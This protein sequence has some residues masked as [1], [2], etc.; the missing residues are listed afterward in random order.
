MSTQ[1]KI[2]VRG[3]I[4]TPEGRYQMRINGVPH[5]TDTRGYG[6]YRAGTEIQTHRITGWTKRVKVAVPVASAGQFRLPEDPQMAAFVVLGELQRLA[7][8]PVV[9]VAYLPERSQEQEL[10]AA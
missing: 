2:D 4:H 5:W 9:P 6:L 3:F 8:T 10:L 1:K 7:A